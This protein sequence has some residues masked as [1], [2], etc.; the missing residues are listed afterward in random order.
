LV[1]SQSA[2][3]GVMRIDNRLH[4]R[5]PADCRESLA[6]FLQN[7]KPTKYKKES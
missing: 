1:R 3:H 7:G 5:T 4:T 2:Q 6:F